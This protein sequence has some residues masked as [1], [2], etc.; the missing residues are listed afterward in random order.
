VLP[1]RVIVQVDM[2][3]TGSTQ[4]DEDLLDAILQSHD[5]QWT[6]GRTDVADADA[7]AAV[8]VA[9]VKTMLHRPANLHIVVA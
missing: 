8:L 9:A 6:A 2:P 3:G 5:D 1:V 4:P 7:A